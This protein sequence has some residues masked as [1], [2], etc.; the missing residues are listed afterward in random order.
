MRKTVQPPLDHSRNNI[1]RHI[2]LVLT[3]NGPEYWNLEAVQQVALRRARNLYYSMDRRQS[4]G[5]LRILCSVKIDSAAAACEPMLTELAPGSS[6][7]TLRKLSKR[8]A[9]QKCNLRDCKCV[10]TH[11]CQCPA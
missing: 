9:P 1:D 2:R 8:A 11:I 4:V 6:Y 5:E 10:V 3:G 7:D